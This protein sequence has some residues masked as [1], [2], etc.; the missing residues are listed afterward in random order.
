M[1]LL[2]DLKFQNKTLDSNK[3]DILITFQNEFEI[4]YSK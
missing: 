4:N 2:T 3:N 1:L